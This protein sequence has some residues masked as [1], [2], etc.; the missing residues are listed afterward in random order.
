MPL[1]RLAPDLLPHDGMRIRFVGLAVIALSVLTFP[2]EVSAQEQSPRWDPD[3]PRFQSWEYAG[4]AVLGAEAFTVRFALDWDEEPDWET[5]ILFD[6]W[7]LEHVVADDPSA[8]DAWRW[9]GDVPYWAGLAWPVI[10]PLTV[11][12]AHGTWD[13]A[14]QMLLM[15]LE[16]FAFFSAALWTTQYLVARE[17]PLA[18]LCDGQR[19]LAREMGVSCDEEKQVRGF[20]G[21]HTG[22]VTTT[23]ALTCMHHGQMDLYGETGDA[24]ACGAAIAAAA[25]TFTSRTVI[26]S[27]Y[28]TDNVLGV[29]LGLVSGGLLP[30]LLHYAHDDDVPDVADSSQPTGPRLMGASVTPDETGQGVRLQLLGV[31]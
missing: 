10:D 3:W 16:S 26:G 8:R 2:A 5:G 6:E 28:A 31:L 14:A 9:A 24:V 21:G 23:A 29:G 19:E 15:N 11:G 20:I 13:I 12:L 7:V 27:H 25:V 18:D 1:G 30:W 17:R 4:M 22:V